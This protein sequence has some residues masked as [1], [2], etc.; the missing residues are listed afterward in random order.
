MLKRTKTKPP[1]EIIKETNALTSGTVLCK[2]T[3]FITS[4]ERERFIWG[5]SHEVPAEPSAREVMGRRI[6]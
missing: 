2:Q 3:K 1:K 5:G 4:V 6:L